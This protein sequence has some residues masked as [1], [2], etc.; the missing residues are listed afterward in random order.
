MV[1][2]HQTGLTYQLRTIK[3][4]ARISFFPSITDASIITIVMNYYNEKTNKMGVYI[5]ININSD[6]P[7]TNNDN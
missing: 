7:E 3:S 4:N 2:F 5:Y 1:K 6:Q